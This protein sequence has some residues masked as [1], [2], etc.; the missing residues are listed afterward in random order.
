MSQPPHPS[1]LPPYLNISEPM[2][3]EDIPLQVALLT[4]EVA[5]LRLTMET[6]ARLYPPADESRNDR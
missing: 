5:Q 3:L 4:M 6:L 1:P 2:E